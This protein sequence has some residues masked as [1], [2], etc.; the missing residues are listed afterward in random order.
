[1][2]KV[3]TKAHERRR[4]SGERQRRGEAVGERAAQHGDGVRVVGR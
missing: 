1:M 4:E 2:A 3:E